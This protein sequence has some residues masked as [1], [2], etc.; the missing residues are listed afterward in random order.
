LALGTT[1][2]TALAGNT[3]LLQLG[4]SSTTALAGNTTI[5]DVSVA[6]L[7]TRLAGGFG[8]NAVQIGDSTDTVTI[9]GNL[10]VTGDTTYSNET[11]Q[12]VEDNTLAFR[13]GDGNAFE[14]LLTAEDATGSDKTITLPNASG[15]VALTSQITGSNSGTNT[16]DEVA[17]T[18]T[19]AGIV[20]LATNT[21]AN[22]GTDTSR[23]LTPS[24]LAA[25]TGS[26]NITTVGTIGSGTWQGSAI[27]TSYISNLSGTN[28]GDE[29][30]ATASV[31]GIVELATAAEVVT[32]TDSTRAVTPS[33]LRAAFKAVTI[34]GDASATS[35]NVDHNFGLADL[36]DVSV[37]VVDSLSSSGTYGQTVMAGVDRTTANRVVVSF[38]SPPASGQTYKVHCVQMG[39]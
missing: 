31:K 32:G 35:F 21:E 30:N 17:A 8:S 13:A 24:N 27:S 39:V 7:K 15:T 33:T 9:P 25:F 6:N 38:G 28:T 2:T 23:A 12:I 34:T 11:I 20:E 16:G 3:S 18:T 14:V 1:S 37:Q 4:T 29:P 26:S 10:V 22:A 5:N 19:V 36:I